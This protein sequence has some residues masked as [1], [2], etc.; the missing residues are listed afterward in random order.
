MEKINDFVLTPVSD[1]N[2][3]LH[4]GSR[5]RTQPVPGIILEA[6]YQLAN[7]R[8]LILTTDDVPYEEGLHI[9]LLDKNMTTLDQ[10]DM[11]LPYQAGI[12]KDL[13]IY[14]DNRL[15]FSFYNDMKFR[16]MIGQGGKYFSPRSAIPGVKYKN[17]FTGKRYL[18]L[19]K[20]G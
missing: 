18:K 6:Q 15:T 19:S 1:V 10:I 5:I 20:A 14:E 12:L 13:E 16:L 17:R 9:L 2:S 11:G 4:L 8:Y 7:N 3:T